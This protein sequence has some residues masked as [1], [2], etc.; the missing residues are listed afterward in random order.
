MAVG[1]GAGLFFHPCFQVAV[2]ALEFLG[3]LVEAFAKLTQLVFT[4]ADHPRIQLASAKPA[5]G[6]GQLAQRADHVDAEVVERDENQ[7][8]AE[9]QAQPLHRAE[10]LRTVLRIVL[11]GADEAVDVADEHVQSIEAGRRADVHQAE[12]VA[13]LLVLL[14]QRRIVIGALQQAVDLRAVEALFESVQQ[15]LALLQRRLQG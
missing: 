14:A 15:R 10:Q 3:H 1:E 13:Q 12:F 7:Q 9:E 6:A 8:Q 11:Q 2:D 5:G 4:A